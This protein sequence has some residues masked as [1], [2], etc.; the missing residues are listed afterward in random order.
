MHDMQLE[1]E[2]LAESTSGASFSSKCAQTVAT[3]VIIVR[4]ACTRADVKRE[5]CEGSSN[6]CQIMRVALND[7]QLDFCHPFQHSGESE[8]QSTGDAFKLHC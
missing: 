5:V 1:K 3:N 6:C 2:K 8:V 7:R 4:F